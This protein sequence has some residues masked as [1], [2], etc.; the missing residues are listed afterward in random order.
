MKKLLIVSAILLGF[1][2]TTADKGVTK[3]EKESA[4]KFLKETEQ[5]VLDAVKGLSENQLK[6]KPAPDKWGVEDCIKHIAVT[7]TA[8]WHLTDSIIKQAAN[9]EKRAEIKMS[10]E[11]VMKNIENRE[12]KVKTAP[13]FEPQNT[14][15]AEPEGKSKSMLCSSL[16]LFIKT[17]WSFSPGFAMISV[18]M[19]I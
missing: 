12:R 17:K 18:G 8:L 11:D 19:N 1:S 6:F 3:K 16:P 5:G 14:A 2:F 4:A 7:E 10:D 9:P 15:C 13:P